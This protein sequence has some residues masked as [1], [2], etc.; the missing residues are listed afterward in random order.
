MPFLSSEL[1]RE[2]VVDRERAWRLR[3][4]VRRVLDKFSIVDLTTGLWA[5]GRKQMR[6]SDKSSR[7]E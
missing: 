4:V 1:N 5:L 3:E 7:N 2:V 6:H